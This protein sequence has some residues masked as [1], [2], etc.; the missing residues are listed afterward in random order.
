M[1]NAARF[2]NFSGAGGAVCDATGFTSYFDINSRH[3]FS[4][5]VIQ[6]IRICKGEF[7]F[8]DP[9]A[10]ASCLMIVDPD[11]AALIPA[12]E[13]GGTKEQRVPQ[14]SGRK[15][16]GGEWIFGRRRF[17]DAFPGLRNPL[18]RRPSP[19]AWTGSAG[20][21]QEKEPPGFS[22]TLAASGPAAVKRISSSFSISKKET[23]P[24]RPL[25]LAV[26]LSWRAVMG[27]P[28]ERAAGE[29]DDFADRGLFEH[30]DGNLHA[31]IDPSLLSSQ[32]TGA[33]PADQ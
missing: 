1:E 18:I 16:V 31:H 2:R 6:M 33:E 23:R 5:M 7:V 28:E 8:P 17:V 11:T 27:E 3:Y 9:Q 19:F 22:N 30:E 25:P 29:L 12:G 14:E 20:G 15:P 4:F 21:S 13:S 24:N 26:I 32:G 10:A